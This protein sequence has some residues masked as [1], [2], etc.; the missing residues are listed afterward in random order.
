MEKGKKNKVG[1]KT[2]KK[3]EP[4]AKKDNG[5]QRKSMIAGIAMIVAALAISVGT[6][7]YYQT[8][9]SGTV[10]GS[11]TAWSFIVND[12]ATTFT[13]DLGDLKPG[14][15]G[16]ITLN[17]SAEDSGLGVSAVVSFSGATNWPANLKLYSD[18]NHTSE[19]VIG[20]DTITRT[21]NAGATDTVVIYYDWPLGSTAESAPTTA[22]TASVQITVV[23][24]QIEQ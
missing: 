14:V 21:L 11:I 2:M 13:A 22:K 15:S 7:A 4:V 9:I 23:G 8:T 17:L 1:T 16:E 3:V 18:E 6:Y 19:L 5:N 10:S 12:E 24:T 20:T